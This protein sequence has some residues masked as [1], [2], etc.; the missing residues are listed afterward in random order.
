[1]LCLFHV[2]AFAEPTEAELNRQFCQSVNGQTETHHLYT[3][4]GGRS[5]IRVDC[6]THDM[7]YEVGL[8]RRSSLDSIQQALFA[9]QVTGKL[10]AVAIYDTDRQEGQFEYMIGRRGSDQSTMTEHSDN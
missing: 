10:P 4:A 3:Y 1:M 9:A 8:D 5:H 2:A 6:E 7:V